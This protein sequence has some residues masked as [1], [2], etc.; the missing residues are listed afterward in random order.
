MFD[1]IETTNKLTA[2]LNAYADAKISYSLA[3]LGAERIE[4]NHILH[5]EGYKEQK[6]DASRK[7]W[8]EH[9][10]KGENDNVQTA[11][12]A[13]IRAEVAKSIAE[14]ELSAAYVLAQK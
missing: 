7:A 3:K 1:L 9:N 13:F 11:Y 12:A 14:A 5:G 6:N 8:L 2:A 4:A 10:M